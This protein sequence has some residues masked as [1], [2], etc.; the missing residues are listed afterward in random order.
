M[1]RARAIVNDANPIRVNAS[2]ILELQ[3]LLYLIKMLDPIALARLIYHAINDHLRP[4]P[5]VLHS[6]Q[7]NANRGRP[8]HR[9][10]SLY[11]KYRKYQPRYQK[12]S[13]LPRRHWKR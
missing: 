8:P 2:G 10:Y 9:K 4:V 1:F 5:L 12:I 7:M 6:L 13:D 11:F 3:N